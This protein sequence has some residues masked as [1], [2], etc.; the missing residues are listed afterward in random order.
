MTYTAHDQRLGCGAARSRRGAFLGEAVSWK[1]D[2]AVA[3]MTVG[4]ILTIN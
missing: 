4:A 1:L 2:L 3:L